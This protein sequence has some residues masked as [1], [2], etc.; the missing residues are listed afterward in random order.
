ML[1][2]QY[3]FPD[4]EINLIGVDNHG[5]RVNAFT[6][7]KDKHTKMTLVNDGSQDV[8]QLSTPSN[9]YSRLRCS[10]TKLT[11]Q[12]YCSKSQTPSEIIN[13]VW[14]KILTIMR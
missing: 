2:V 1:Y 12:G 6:V 13:D 5:N 10:V 3:S 4:K 11:E 8:I 9:V 14:T 7:R